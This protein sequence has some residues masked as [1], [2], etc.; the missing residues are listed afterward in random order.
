MWGKG[1]HLSWRLVSS[2]E[3]HGELQN[4]NDTTGF[5]PPRGKKGAK[6]VPLCVSESLAMGRRYFPLCFRISLGGAGRVPSQVKQLP[7]DQGQFSGEDGQLW[8]VPAN[9]HSHWRW[10]H[11]VGRDLDGTLTKSIAF[12]LHPPS[13]TEW[14]NE[15]TCS[16]SNRS[17][18]M[19][20]RG[21]L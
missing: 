8:T 3:S 7:F 1:C 21:S 18:N 4:M 12:T 5:V 19:C 17:D 13:L 11:A 15:Y 10:T 9:G 2:A 20:F 6:S 16:L 14:I